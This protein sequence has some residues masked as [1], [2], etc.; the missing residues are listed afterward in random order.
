MFKEPP[1]KIT[2]LQHPLVKHLTKLRLSKKYRESCQTLLITG[3]TV[4]EEVKSL[5]TPLNVLVSNEISDFPPETT[6]L[7]TPEILKKI[8]DLP[9]PDPLLAELPYPKNSNLEEASFLV[10]FDKISDP[11]N[12]GTLMRTALALNWDGAIFLPECV[13]PF[14][15]KA[16]RASRSA[17]YKLPFLQMDWSSLTS[18]AK[19]KKIPLLI[20]DIEGTP[21]SQLPPQASC[22]LVLSHESTGPSAEALLQGKQVTIPMPGKMESLNVAIAGSILMYV[23]RGFN[24]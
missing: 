24:K 15:D 17:C 5:A 6:H 2:S 12:L 11:G 21:L 20:A 9:A 7:V 1:K 18:F 13:D 8:T 3:N 23:L 14:N 16:L 10:V 4:F 19:R 22:L